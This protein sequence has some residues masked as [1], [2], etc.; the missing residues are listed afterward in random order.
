MAKILAWFLSFTKL[1]KIVT[2]IQTFLSGKKVYLS[3]IAIALPALISIIT[4]FADQGTSYLLTVMHTPE[5]DLLLNGLA[6]MGL[7]AAISKAANPAKDP[8]A[9][10]Q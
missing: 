3:G 10:A 1:G 6:V 2:P 4:K 9:P 7:R 8:N 5:W